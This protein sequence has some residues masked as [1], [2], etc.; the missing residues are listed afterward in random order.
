VE[1]QSNEKS[2]HLATL[3]FNSGLNELEL[4]A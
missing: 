2:P 3:V 1:G 4:F